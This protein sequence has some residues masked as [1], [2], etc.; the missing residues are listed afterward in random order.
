ML[1]TEAESLKQ[2]RRCLADSSHL[3]NDDKGISGTTSL[4]PMEPH[5]IN[6]GMI[7]GQ[8]KNC[9]NLEAQHFIPLQQNELTNVVIQ[10]SS[11]ETTVFLTT[12]LQ[13]TTILQ[14]IA[15]LLTSL[16]KAVAREKSVQEIGRGKRRM[17][18]DSSP[19]SFEP[20]DLYWVLPSSAEP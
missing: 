17:S 10:G 15:A 13:S 14:K 1:E 9:T 6:G 5:K 8:S 7:P 19:T 2:T 16:L 12:A 18:A 11:R 20:F 3:P 4:F